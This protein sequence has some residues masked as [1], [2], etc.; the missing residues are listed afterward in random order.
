MT[1]FLCSIHLKFDVLL[2]NNIVSFEEL[3]MNSFKLLKLCYL[4]PQILS[5]Q[6]VNCNA[7]DASVKNMLKIE[8]RSCFLLR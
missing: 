5:E 1:A 4:L 3:D 2:T 7:S 8:P 6:S